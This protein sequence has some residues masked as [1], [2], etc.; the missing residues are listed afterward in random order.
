MRVGIPRGLLFYR[1]IPLWETFFE[2]LGMEW[3]VSPPTTERTIREG[4]K[5]LPGDLC[6]PI[7]IFFGH[8]ESIRRDVDFLF[9]PRY[10]S[11][12]PD[13]YMC[14]KLMG[15]PDM[16]LSAFE[17]LPPLI[18]D[19]I[20]FKAQ[21]I[22]A[23]ENFYLKAGR[24]FTKD[25]QKVM[26]AYRLGVERQ[27]RFRSLLQKGLPFEE[28]QA[29]SRLSN[30]SFKREGDERPKLGIIGRPYYLYDSFLRRPVVEQLESR[31]YTLL[32]TE[33][34]SDPEIEREV[35]RLRKRIYWSFGKEMF[36][37]AIHFAQKGIVSGLINLASF[38]CGQDSFNF[39]LIQHAVKEKIPVLSLVFDEHLSHLGFS[40]R[41]EAFLEMIQRRRNRG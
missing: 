20:H 10:I 32:T 24:L 19:P 28:A 8:V 25:K 14:P 33:A 38:G 15:L 18:D 3:V 7:K 21:G 36:G 41:I 1:Y 13:A 6:L 23:E 16:L 12:E 2:A 9:V 31:G 40:T 4:S 39:E 30:G 26:M 34:L 29:L 11:V 27:A 17:S 5:L 37:S 35:G 22:K